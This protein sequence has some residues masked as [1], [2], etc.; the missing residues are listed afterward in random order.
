MNH[1]TYPPKPILVPTKP[2][3]T[4]CVAHL[5]VNSLRHKL[6][7]VSRLLSFNNI[8]I[9]GL[10]ETK[11]CDDLDDGE[12]DIPSYKVLRKDRN[13]FGG[14]VAFYVASHLRAQRY[15]DPDCAS[16][17]SLWLK[18]YLK[19]EDYLIG[20]VYRPPS[21]TSDFW[22]QLRQSWDVLL[23]ANT[24][25]LGD[26][27]A[28]PLNPSDSGWKHLNFISSSHG[29][30]NCILEPTRITANCKSCL[31]LMFTNIDPSPTINI[32][33][34]HVSDHQLIIGLFGVGEVSTRNTTRALVSFR[35]FQHFSLLGFALL[36]RQYGID[37]LS[38]TDN[39]D[40]MWDEWYTKFISA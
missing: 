15:H 20:V 19:G 24:I 32:V 37:S 4:L 6:D 30:R 7:D 31:D 2:A 28:D 29:L 34:T 36:L 8:D 35:D 1:Q 5:N 21:V 39:V 26:F 16:I 40:V 27:N 3:T 13:K 11:L 12:I 17:E 14:G 18:L 33:E 38:P 22:T 25:I 10:S 9:L 23:P